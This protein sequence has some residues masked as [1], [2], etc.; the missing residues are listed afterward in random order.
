VAHGVIDD[1][2]AKAEV[3]EQQLRQQATKAGEKVEASQ[4][5]ATKKI[6]TSIAKAEAFA[7][8]QPI[9]AAGIAFAAGVI[10]TA[11]LRR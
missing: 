2:A 5:A 7:K 10:T 3:V 9:T 1:T 11:L 4:E 8:E 6:E